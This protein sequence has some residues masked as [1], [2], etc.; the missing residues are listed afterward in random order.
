[1]P[2]IQ[3]VAGET[4]RNAGVVRGQRSQGSALAPTLLTIN[5]RVLLPPTRTF[6]KFRFVVLSAM[7]GGLMPLPTNLS[8]NVGASGSLLAIET[9]PVCDPT[10]AGLNR[11]VTTTCDP[12]A[13][14]NGAAGETIW[15]AGLLAT[16]DVMANAVAAQIAHGQREIAAAAERDV[17][18]IQIRRAE[19]DVRGAR[20]CRPRA[21][22]RGDFLGRQ[23]GVENA[24]A[25]NLPR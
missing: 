5:V 6:P 9:A 16:S 13:T 7:S 1:M 17:S 18:K 24:D 25:R 21:V 4:T 14:L 11:S 19:S 15:K 10:L 3:G 23:R 12:V 20:G 22:E 2:R 8:A